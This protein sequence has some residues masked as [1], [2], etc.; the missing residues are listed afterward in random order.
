MSL[1]SI[2]KAWRPLYLKGATVLLAGTCIDRMKFA[3]QNSLKMKYAG[4]T[5]SNINALDQQG[6]NTSL[7]LAIENG[8]KEYLYWSGAPIA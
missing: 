2:Q 8:N 1:F 5:F 6:K 7:H 4:Y 3:L